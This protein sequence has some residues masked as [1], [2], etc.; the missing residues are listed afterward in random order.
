MNYTTLIDTCHLTCPCI[1][2]QTLNSIPRSDTGVVIDRE[3][4]PSR[5]CKTS[6]LFAPLAVCVHTGCSTFPFDTPTKPLI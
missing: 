6:F 3:P 1:R 2:L 5:M 4:Q